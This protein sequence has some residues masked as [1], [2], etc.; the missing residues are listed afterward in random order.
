MRWLIGAGVVTNYL[1]AVGL[2]A[3]FH[4][5]LFQRVAQNGSVFAVLFPHW[6]GLLVKA[7]F[8]SAASIAAYCLRYSATFSDMVFRNVPVIFLVAR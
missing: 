3:Y 6:K 2:G 1:R 5:L 8:S 7:L 4:Y